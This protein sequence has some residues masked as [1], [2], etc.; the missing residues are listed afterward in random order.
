MLEKLFKLSEHQTTFQKETI[1]GL[2]TFAAMAYIL[3]VNPLILAETGMDR[4]TL[5]T[6]TALAA[7]LGCFLMAAWT[8]YPIAIAPGMGTNA[9]FAFFIVLAMKVPWQG[10][11]ALVFWN[12]ILF[13]ILS[14]TGI[15]S[16]LVDALPH[17]IQIGI[18]CGIGFFIAFLGLQSSGIVIANP[19]TL[20]GSGDFLSPVALLTIGGL[21]LICIL[22]LKRIPGAIV[23]VILLITFAGMLIPTGESTVTAK[24]SGIISLPTSIG[25]TFLQLDWLYPF[26]H[27][28]ETLPLLVTLLLL[29]LFDSIGTII[30][31][32]RRAKLTD[33]SGKLPKMGKA[34]TADS[35]ATVFGALLGTSTNTSYVES[36]AGVEAGGRTGLTSIVVGLCFL[37]A[38]F[39]NPLIS[40]IPAAATAPALIIV[41]LFMAQGIQDLDFGDFSEVAPAILTALLIPLTF[42]IMKGIALG[43]I[44]Y[45]CIQAVQAGYKKVSLGSYLLT[46]LFIGFFIMDK[47]TGTGH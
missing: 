18:Q 4:A 7:A 36:A 9:Y 45:T 3:A 37:F 16:K 46:A 39:F 14:I 6:V 35:V 28:T 44:L 10:A 47:F 1:A 41:G 40:I 22:T 5:V 26:R 15:R 13:F 24:P 20:L 17:A 8:N 32:S 34:L 33:K 12:G 30:G 38:L 23:I 42:S 2:T 29:D 19:A 43:L 27:F 25:S 21:I 31:V 11:L